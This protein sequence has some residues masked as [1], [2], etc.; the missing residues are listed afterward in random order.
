[1]LT[2]HPGVSNLLAGKASQG[3]GERMFPAV[4]KTNSGSFVCKGYILVISTK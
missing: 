2:G 3:T 1:M 4:Q